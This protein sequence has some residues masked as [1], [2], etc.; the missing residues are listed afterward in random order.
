MKSTSKEVL[1]LFTSY[2]LLA[3]H[4]NFLKKLLFFVESLLGLVE[5]LQGGVLEMILAVTIL[6][7]LS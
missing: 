6:F 1:F 4:E 5:E 3:L 7:S 2:L